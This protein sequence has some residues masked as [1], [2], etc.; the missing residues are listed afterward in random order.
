MKKIKGFTITGMTLTGFKCFEDDVSFDFGDTTFITASNGRGKSSIADAIAF[1]FV[2]TPFFGDKGLDRLQN[3]NMQEMSVSVDFVDDRGKSHNLTRTRKRDTSI[4]YDGIAVRQ[5]DLNEAFG[6]RDIFLSILNPLYFINVL[7][8]GGKGMLE[9]LLPAVGHGDVLAAL[10][11]SSR[12]VLAGQPLLSPEVFIKNRRAKLKELN[13]ELIA[14]SGKKELLDSQREKRSAKREELQISI[15]SISDEMEELSM[16]RDEGRDIEEEKGVLE[17]LR[18]QRESLLSEASD[19]SLDKDAKKLMDEIKETEKTIAEQT[20]QQYRS[21]FTQQIAEAEAHLKALRAEFDRRK[22]ALVDAVAGYKCPVCATA[23]TEENAAAIREGMQKKLSAVVD[24][25]N[26]VK[27]ALIAA[28]ADDSA[29]M[30]AF[31]RQKEEALARE[32]EKLSELNQRLQEVNVA[33]ELDREDCAERLSGLDERISAQEYAVRNGRWS[34]EQAERFAELCGRKKEA[35]AQMKA[36]GSD[37]GPDDYAALIAETEAEISRIKR[38]INEAVMYMA[39]RVELM[40]GGLKMGSAEI[41]LT[42]LVKS[43]GE[44]RDCFRFSYE[45]RDYRCLSLSEQVRAGLEVALL[46]QRLSGRNYPIFVDNGESICNFGR[47]KPSGQVLIARVA[48]GQE[49]QVTYRNRSEQIGQKEQ[50]K[51]A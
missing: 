46:I 33:R 42:E 39:K 9:K 14:C 47:A 40:L 16:L 30:E 15:D 28:K 3:A 44:I 8:E 2:G 4:A 41:V 25:A 35:E 5:S 6:G 50:I 10:P 29:A 27:N 19:S 23:V 18:M 43:T 38:L 11:A 13:E 51:A 26:A 36:I 48:N 1:A 21:P 7:G 20:A 24:E 12:E 37:D 32:G 49:L 17:G 45:G 22:S 34:Q 31:D